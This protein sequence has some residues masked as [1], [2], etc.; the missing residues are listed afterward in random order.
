MENQE[1]IS[2]LIKILRRMSGFEIGWILRDMSEDFQFDTKILNYLC[3]ELFSPPL[4]ISELKEEDIEVFLKS[5]PQSVIKFLYN[6]YLEFRP[7]IATIYELKKIRSMHDEKV[8][9]EES[10]RIII[11]EILKLYEQREISYNGI[12]LYFNKSICIKKKNKN[13]DIYFLILE[14]VLQCNGVIRIIIISKHLSAKWM[15]VRFERS[16]TEIYSQYIF[17][18]IWGFYYGEFRI[19][20]VEGLIN[21]NLVYEDKIIS[22]KKL[23]LVKESESHLTIRKFILRDNGKIITG[24]GFVYPKKEKQLPTEVKYI[25]FCVDCGL[26]LHYGKAL[27]N[28]NRICISFLKSENS[29]EH[30]KNLIIYFKSEFEEIIYRPKYII[31]STEIQNINLS[32]RRSREDIVLPVRLKYGIKYIFIISEYLSTLDELYLSIVSEDISAIPS[33]INRKGVNNPFEKYCSEDKI[34][35]FGIK[36]KTFRIIIH[37][38][39]IE[40]SE[41]RINPVGQENIN[42]VYVDIY[43]VDKNLKFYSRFFSPL[44][45]GFH[46]YSENCNQIEGEES[47][48]NIY[49]SKD[50]NKDWF[51]KKPR[52][53]VI[54]SNII[55][56]YLK[57]SEEI[58]IVLDSKNHKFQSKVNNLTVYEFTSNLEG[59]IDI[60]PII[61]KIES[62]F[63]NH[64]YINIYNIVIIIYFLIRKYIIYKLDY[65]K[66]S[67][68][69]L[70]MKLKEFENG[71]ENYSIKVL[72]VLEYWEEEIKGKTLEFQNLLDYI[73]MYKK[74]LSYLINY[75]SNEKFNSE[76]Y[77]INNL[78][79]ILKYDGNE[80]ILLNSDYNLI[81][82]KLLLLKILYNRGID[83]IEVQRNTTEVKKIKKSQGWNR[84][85]E[86]LGLKSQNIFYTKKIR[87]IKLENAKKK[88]FL[89]LQLSIAGANIEI[90]NLFK[91][92]ELKLKKNYSISMIEV[93]EIQ[94]SN[95]YDEND[96]EP[97]TKYLKLN[98]FSLFIGEIGSISIE[99]TLKTDQLIKIIFPS[100][101]K[102]LNSNLLE[103]DDYNSIY[104]NPN[105]FSEN[106]IFFIALKKGKG[107][108]IIKIYDSMHPYKISYAGIIEVN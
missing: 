83:I 65:L 15:K 45:E 13:E 88:I 73:Q 94:N 35:L 77:I 44:E 85:L 40:E 59:S 61:K 92:L 93:S 107:N 99:R 86:Q 11:K 101:L 95:K 43:E 64:N 9:E 8:T 91:L 80:L 53:K 47:R 102:V 81:E 56:Y 48:V 105:N 17:L 100:F 70:F 46:V 16:D 4:L 90:F 5:L 6:K 69:Y 55:E 104:I 32:A 54:R 98:K 39:T 66:E 41:L 89:D 84:V 79:K 7:L 26:G 57:H 106:N 2:H 71:K 49:S 10:N 62:N 68:S 12:L 78:Y 19:D 42:S 25:A 36:N 24:E 27:L 21:V 63:F 20:R 58:Q 23:F 75:N 14:D 74:K 67:I 29:L 108:L 33:Q 96:Q 72:S 22:V 1:S 76:E 52:E 60:V 51:I 3:E 38:I 34:K 37:T 82:L 30:S 28:D 31:N 97:Y 50:Y 103:I 87:K 18:D